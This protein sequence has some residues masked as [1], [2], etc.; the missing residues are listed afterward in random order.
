MKT[1]VVCAMGA[2]LAMPVW[3]G[4]IAYTRDSDAAVGLGGLA[5]LKRSRRQPRRTTTRC[6]DVG[7][8][9]AA[10]AAAAAVVVVAL[11]ARGIDE[12]LHLNPWIPLRRTFCTTV[13]GLPKAGRMLP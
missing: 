2:A 10:A 8:W 9:R 6:T 5:L 13:I 1:V 7:A 3:A 4:I 11:A 12:L